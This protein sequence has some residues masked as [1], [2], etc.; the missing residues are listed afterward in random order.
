[1]QMKTKMGKTQA[2]SLVHLKLAIHF[3]Y[4]WIHKFTQRKQIAFRVTVS[5]LSSFI[6]P[7][8]LVFTREKI[9][10]NRHKEN[11]SDRVSFVFLF[12]LEFFS[13]QL[14]TLNTDVGY[15]FS[16]IVYTLICWNTPSVSNTERVTGHHSAH[17]RSMHHNFCIH[18]ISS[19]IKLF[20]ISTHDL[21]SLFLF[22]FFLL[23]CL[24]QQVSK[25]LGESLDGGC[26]SQ[27]PITVT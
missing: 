8:I 9:K 24:G 4:E 14:N 1:M 10:V 3:E 26:L 11:N 25:R 5:T 22:H 2:L 19:I 27:S 17:G 21:I 20:F 16:E 12:E 6:I 7:D 15:Q 13:A 23:C 18:V